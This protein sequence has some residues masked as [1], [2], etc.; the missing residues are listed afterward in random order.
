MK[1]FISQ[2][3]NTIYP[4]Q[5][6]KAEVQTCVAMNNRPEPKKF[7]L[8]VCVFV[9]VLVPLACCPVIILAKRNNKQRTCQVT[10]DNACMNRKNLSPT[11]RGLIIARKDI[12]FAFTQKTKV[13]KGWWANLS[14]S[15]TSTEL[16][17]KIPL[18]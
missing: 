8:Y 5:F 10:G 4:A 2:P 15:K 12:I 1:T 9:A 14:Y 13:E 7:K 18:Q 3:K 16:R 6:V 17:L 11:I